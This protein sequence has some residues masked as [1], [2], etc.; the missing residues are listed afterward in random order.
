MGRYYSS[1]GVLLWEV[2]VDGEWYFEGN[3]EQA[4]EVAQ[5]FW[6]SADFYGDCLL[7]SAREFYG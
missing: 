6:G 2:I 1:D 3:Y 7:I 5:S 4:E